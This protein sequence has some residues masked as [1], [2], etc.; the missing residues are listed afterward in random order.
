MGYVR[1]TAIFSHLLTSIQSLHIYKPKDK[2]K[3]TIKK[4]YY[5][6][7]YVYA[8]VV[9]KCRAADLIRWP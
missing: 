7:S 8:P 9:F 6:M 2:A 3:P 4:I 1:I 5:H